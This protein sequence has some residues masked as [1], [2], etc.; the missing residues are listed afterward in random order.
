MLIGLLLLL[1][2]YML[3]GNAEHQ[4]VSY[5][6]MGLGGLM[7]LE[8]ALKLLAYILKP[9]AEL[10]QLILDIFGIDTSP[11]K[12]T[13]YWTQK[14]H[15]SGADEYECSSCGKR[16]GKAHSRCPNCHLKMTKIEY[17]PS[18]VDEIEPMDALFRD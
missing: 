6:M 5:I 13:A 3:M 17:D 9:L 8:K 15:I 10:L 14:A 18:W 1:I 7:V 2:G 11:R 12:E 4:T 16:F